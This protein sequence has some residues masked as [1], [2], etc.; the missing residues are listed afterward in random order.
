MRT[1][2]QWAAAGLVRQTG[3][4]SMLEWRL[5]YWRSLLDPKLRQ[6]PDP[7]LRNQMEE[8]QAALRDAL[9]LLSSKTVNESMGD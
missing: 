7:I 6:L 9:H 4:R 8:I 5:R 3:E 2:G 1:V